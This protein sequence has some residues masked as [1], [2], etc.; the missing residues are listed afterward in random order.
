MP[1]LSAFRRGRR[2]LVVLVLV[3]AACNAHSSAPTT[4]FPGPSGS[5]VGR[6][7][8]VGGP[9]NT[10]I[11]VSGTVIIA[12]PNLTATVPVRA[13]DQFEFDMPPGHYWLTGQ[14]PQYNSGSSAGC[15]AAH[16]V[17][18]T[19]GETTQADVLCPMR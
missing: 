18:V 15:Q 16:P 5:V 7:I 9:V 14:S 6:L 2:A 12:G 1:S 17:T 8:M 11:P 10:T 19:V 3:G 4:S 13:G